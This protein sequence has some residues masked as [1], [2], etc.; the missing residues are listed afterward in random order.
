MK[1]NEVGDG[2]HRK[3]LQ[4]DSKMKEEEKHPPLIR[5]PLAE[6]LLVIAW[7]YLCDRWHAFPIDPTSEMA[8]FG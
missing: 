1:L 2:E 3:R 6:L 4:Q 8:Y 7:F 5:S